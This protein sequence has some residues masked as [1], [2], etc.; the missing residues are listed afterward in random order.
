MDGRRTQGRADAQKDNVA[1]AHLY[2]EMKRCR[3]FGR[4]PLSG[5]GRDSVTGRQTDWC[6]DGH[7]S[8]T[9]VLWGNKNKKGRYSHIILTIND[10]LQQQIRFN[11]SIFGNKCCRCNEG[12][13][14]SDRWGFAN[15]KIPDQTGPLGAVLSGVLLFSIHSV[16]QIHNNR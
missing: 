15:S 11:G 9:Y 6:P 7:I 1:L 8:K 4:I 12:S 2:H 5:L 10:S 3:K 16:I 14:Y 13:L